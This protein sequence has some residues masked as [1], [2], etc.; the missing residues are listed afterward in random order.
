MRK[1]CGGFSYVEILVA[2]SLFGILIMAALPLL[3]Q[4]GRNLA[5]AEDGYE[6]FLGA[7]GI[8][9]AVRDTGLLSP[10]D[11][12]LAASDAAARF[13][14]GTYRVWIFSENA[15]IAEA[16]GESFG[17]ACAPEITAELSGDLSVIVVVVWN[18]DMFVTGRA[19][20]G[21]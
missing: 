16:F 3:N 9:L 18:E 19:V 1:L 12:A 20:G 15:D 11:A 4:A 2:L 17:S 10:A 21:I 14:I 13:G 8:K 7:Q 6:A 5:F